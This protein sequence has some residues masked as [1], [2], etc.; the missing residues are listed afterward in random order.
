LRDAVLLAVSDYTYDDLEGV[1][2]K[3]R[4]KDELLS[5]FHALTEH[6]TIERLYLTQFVVR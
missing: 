2:G 3:A 6:V 5:R 4:L 1:D